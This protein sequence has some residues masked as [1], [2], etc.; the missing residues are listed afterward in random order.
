MYSFILIQ[1]IESWNQQVIVKELLYLFLRVYRGVK[2]IGFKY[3]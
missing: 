2:S 1:L 3:C